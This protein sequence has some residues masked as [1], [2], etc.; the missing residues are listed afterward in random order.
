MLRWRQRRSDKRRLQQTDPSGS[1]KCNIACEDL[2]RHKCCPVTVSRPYK[3][4]P[5]ASSGSQIRRRS[6]ISK[7]A[8]PE[9]PNRAYFDA[10][11]RFYF[12]I[13]VQRT[14]AVVMDQH[15][16]PRLVGVAAAAARGV[17]NVVVKSASF[18]CRSRRYRSGGQT[19][20]AVVILASPKRSAIRRPDW[21]VTDVTFRDR[22]NRSW[23]PDWGQEGTENSSRMMK[24]RHQVKCSASRP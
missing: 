7:T 20:S 3:N 21:S 9:G 12:E 24:S 11:R 15:A 18:R 8:P 17:V 16:S 14:N 1:W 23:P 2:G 22:W 10:G 6:G 5:K 19:V 13:A 4:S